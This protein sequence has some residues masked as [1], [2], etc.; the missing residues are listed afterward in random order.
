MLACDLTWVVTGQQKTM[1]KAPNLQD[2][3]VSQQDAAKLKDLS[4]VYK[5]EGELFSDL[6]TSPVACSSNERMSE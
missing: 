2:Q 3:L 1:W 4:S 6:D 5:V